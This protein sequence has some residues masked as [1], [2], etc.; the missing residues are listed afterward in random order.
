MRTVRA[1]GPL[2]FGDAASPRAELVFEKG[3][4]AKARSTLAAYLGGVLYELG[5]IDVETLNS[6]LALVARTRK[7]QGA[8]LC[9]LSA[10]GVADV[11]AA[12]REQIERRLA[13]I[14]TQHLKPQ[15]A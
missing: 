13:D 15:T 9:E 3:L 11:E 10:V 8:V 4:V 6:S 7:L 1:S 12:L 14:V 5:R 2:V